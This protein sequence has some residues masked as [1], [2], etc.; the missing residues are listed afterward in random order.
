[1]LRFAICNKNP[2]T[3]KDLSAILMTDTR[4]IWGLNLQKIVQCHLEH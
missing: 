4:W 3:E 2:C 1:M